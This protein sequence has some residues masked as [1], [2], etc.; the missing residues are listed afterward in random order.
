VLGARCAVRG[1]RSR[2][3]PRPPTSAPRAPST[4]NHARR[5]NWNHS[6]LSH[7]IDGRPVERLVNKDAGALFGEIKT[8]RDKALAAVKA[9]AGK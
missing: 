1:R 3:D 5:P 6:V 4:T 9:A 7:F 8:N 2:S